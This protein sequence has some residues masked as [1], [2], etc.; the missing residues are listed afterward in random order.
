MSGWAL[1]ILNI[2]L[3]GLRGAYSG[4]LCYQRVSRANLH[5]S[6]MGAQTSS[7]PCQ[8]EVADEGLRGLKRVRHVMMQQLPPPN[9]TGILSSPVRLQVR[10]ALL[11]LGLRRDVLTFL[12]TFCSPSDVGH[13][14]G[15][16]RSL[17][18]CCEADAVWDMLLAADFWIAP[19]PP[20][21]I[22][23][24]A[25]P[26]LDRFVSRHIS[27]FNSEIL[28][29][30]R[31]TSSDSSNVSKQLLIQRWQ[32]EVD[33]RRKQALREQIQQLQSERDARLA[34]CRLRWRAVIRRRR[35][36]A[37]TAWMA[38]FLL[39]FRWSMASLS[40]QACKCMA[41]YAYNLFHKVSWLLFQLAPGA[42]VE[43][44]CVVTAQRCRKRRR[45]LAGD[46][47]PGVHVRYACRAGLASLCCYITAFKQN[48]VWA[49]RWKQ[50]VAVGCGLVAGWS[51][52]VT[53]LVVAGVL[54]AVFL[55]TAYCTMWRAR[56]WTGEFAAVAQRD[57]Q[58]LSITEDY[59]DKIR[60]CRVSLGLPPEDR[61][62]SCNCCVL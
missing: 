25:R 14:A 17:Y 28:G 19:L 11:S 60:K 59:Q 41:L 43:G 48:W 26:A 38:L 9:H 12:L 44:L 49:R 32:G 57:Q 34:E 51:A 22:L 24:P 13:V 61:K 21:A 47:A 37:V 46:D 15:A 10:E 39:S 3:L 29:T 40:M 62:S 18:E 1:G 54:L 33:L 7:F 53:A 6:S 4:K 55:M 5:G 50:V 30:A 42:V 31:Q 58:E 16:D 45:R 8:G 52:F 2:P 35:A 56:C 20:L 36:L 27:R 23:R